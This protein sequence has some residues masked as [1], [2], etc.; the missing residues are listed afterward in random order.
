MYTAKAHQVKKKEMPRKNE[1]LPFIF[2]MN[3]YH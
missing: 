3:Y 1:E 2:Y